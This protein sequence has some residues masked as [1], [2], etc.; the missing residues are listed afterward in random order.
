MDR[1]RRCRFSTWSFDPGGAGLLPPEADREGFVLAIAANPKDVGP[2]ADLLV[3][4]GHGLLGVA[5]TREA[6]EVIQVKPEELW[7][8][9]KDESRSARPEAVRRRRY[10]ILRAEGLELPVG[11]DAIRDD[12]L[13]AAAASFTSYLWSSRQTRE[14]PPWVIPAE[15]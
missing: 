9:L 14:S 4:A 11:C 13:A 12:Q 2:L 3:R 15:D 8:G 10:E 5:P 1:L 7:K 6:T